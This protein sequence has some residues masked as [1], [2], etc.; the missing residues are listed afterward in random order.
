MMLHA[1]AARCE[2][3][4]GRALRKLPFL[5]HANLIASPATVSLEAFLDALHRSAAR[6]VRPGSGAPRPVCLLPW[7]PPL[8][9]SPGLLPWPPQGAPRCMGAQP[10]PRPSRPFP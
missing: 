9:S 10:P 1:L 4:S 2:G 5:A 6:A 7:P 3:L 8:A